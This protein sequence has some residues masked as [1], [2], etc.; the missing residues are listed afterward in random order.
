MAEKQAKQAAKVVKEIVTGEKKEKEKPVK[1]K[2]EEDM[3][4]V[5]TTPKGHKKGPI[6]FLVCEFCVL[7]QS[8]LYRHVA[9]H[10]Q[11]LQS[12]RSRI[13]LV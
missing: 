6:V 10:G 5:N 7:I 1:E 2:K 11:R 9:T 13:C 12:Y 8:L 4:F 3:P